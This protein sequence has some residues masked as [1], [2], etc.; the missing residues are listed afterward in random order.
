MDLA[1]VCL[2][3]DLS[4][5]RSDMGERG[6]RWSVVSLASSG[7]KTDPTDSPMSLSVSSHFCAH[8][9][10]SV[11][12]LLLSSAVISL[13][14]ADTSGEWAWHWVW[15]AY[16]GAVGVALGVVSIQHPIHIVS[17]QVNAWY[18]CSETLTIRM[19]LS[20]V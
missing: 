6:R 17:S 18:F 1:I 16:G 10:C 15:L 19:H 3:F 9:T 2:T 4:V 5:C 14:R 12:K 7:Y 11:R 8:C 20:N 13:S